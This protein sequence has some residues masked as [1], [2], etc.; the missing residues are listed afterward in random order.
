LAGRTTSQKGFTFLNPQSHDVE[1][2][3]FK[4]VHIH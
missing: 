4:H 3:E 1:Y 2:H